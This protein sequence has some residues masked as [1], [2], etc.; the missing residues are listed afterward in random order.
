[1]VKLKFSRLNMVKAAKEQ[2]WTFGSAKTDK[3]EIHFMDD[4]AVGE[5]V[6]FEKDGEQQQ[7]DDGDYTTDDKVITLE[8]GVITEIKDKDTSGE[9]KTDQA[10]DEPVVN[11]QVTLEMW[12]QLNDSVLELQKSFGDIVKKVEDLGGKD[13][14]TTEEVEN[15]KAEL[16]SALAKSGNAKLVDPTPPND[17]T[18]F[19]Y[20]DNF[21]VKK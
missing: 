19:E 17:E 13:K 14:E 21:K 8:K 9:T 15:L 20:P 7:P 11:T 10:V 5:F 2:K 18:K 4:L 3:G 6:W 12:N 1:M 16:K